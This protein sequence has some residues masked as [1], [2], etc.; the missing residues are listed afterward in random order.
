MKRKAGG[1]MG[2]HGKPK[3]NIKGD[4]K[5]RDTKIGTKTRSGKRI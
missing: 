1:K 5:N 4:V 3:L 2:G